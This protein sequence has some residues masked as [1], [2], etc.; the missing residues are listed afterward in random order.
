M[1]EELAE[2]AY[3]E[4]KRADHSI[5]VSL[6]YTRT[7]DIIK[8]TI[9]RLISAMDISIIQG[10]EYAK[11]EKKI[12]SI[13]QSARL[14]ADNIVKL[15]PQMKKCVD[16]YHRL[17]NIDRADYTKKEEYRKNVALIAKVGSKKVEVGMEE[18]K[19]FF[20]F[21]V[22]FS[23]GVAELT[24]QKKF[25]DTKKVTII[26]PAKSTKKAEKK[27]AAKKAAAKKAAKKTSKTKKTVKKTYKL[28]PHANHR[29]FNGF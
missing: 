6:K 7:V 21:A 20:D 19:D 5:Y 9:K 23:R 4:I 14:R 1:I 26:Y 17:K 15:Y 2:S 8:N 10:L 16:F 25:L 28:N 27:A 13:P 18:L 12:P 22:V 11:Q 29:G 3:E 24:A